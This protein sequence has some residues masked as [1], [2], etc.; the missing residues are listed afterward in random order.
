MRRKVCVRI[1]PCLR[2]FLRVLVSMDGMEER[3]VPLIAIILRIMTSNSST[4]F[5]SSSADGAPASSSPKP[6]K[7]PFIPNNSI[8]ISASSAA[9]PPKPS[10]SSS[11][12]LLKSSASALSHSHASND[13]R[14][15]GT[16][17]CSPNSFFPV[18]SK[19]T[20]SKLV[21]VHMSSHSSLDMSRYGVV[22]CG[23]A[24]ARHT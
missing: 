20:Y 21:S 9:N 4:S 16:P 1:L 15:L 19:S 14:T 6:C 7:A 18:C 2:P 24:T 23:I 17:T 11:S 10:S 5:A 13:S 12:S 22:D 8:F 3:N